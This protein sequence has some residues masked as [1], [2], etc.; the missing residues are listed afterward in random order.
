MGDGKGNYS[1]TFDFSQSKELLNIV[2][3]YKNA[4]GNSIFQP[5]Q[6]KKPLMLIA[7]ELDNVPGVYD[8]RSVI[9]TTHWK[10][11]IRFAF[12]DIHALN[13]A[14]SK[15]D[16]AKKNEDTFLK[17]KKR[18]AEW[19]RNV[20]WKTLITEHMPSSSDA[21]TIMTQHIDSA[22]YSFHWM[23][24]REI[25]TVKS[26]EIERLGSTELIYKGKIPNSDN[27]DFITQWDVKFK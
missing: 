4:E 23:L 11:G 18:K 14:L 9:D 15:L 6:F 1:F 21:N 13:S 19:I 20:D 22:N 3:A 7:E 12:V 24:N 5:S 27:V 26:Y 17:M 8:S 10:L 2:S 16:R 25:K